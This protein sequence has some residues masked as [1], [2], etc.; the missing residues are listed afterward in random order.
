[1]LKK[2]EFKLK[3]LQK[4]GNL[5]GYGTG[6]P[7]VTAKPICVSSITARTGGGRLEGKDMIA[8]S[9]YISQVNTR[10]GAKVFKLKDDVG[11]RTDDYK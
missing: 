11:T 8:D 2:E 5:D 4:N 7:G 1:M 6:D 3:R 9:K 10:E